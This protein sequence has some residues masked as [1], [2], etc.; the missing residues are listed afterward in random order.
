M[1]GGPVRYAEDTLGVHRTDAAVTERLGELAA[2]N[3]VASG[4]H[5]QKRQIAERLLLAEADI[6]AD[7]RAANP[8]MSQ[9]A[10][11]RHIKTALALST[12]CQALRGEQIEVQ[13]Q[14]D[15]AENGVREIEFHVRHG[16][17]R[18][19]ELGGLLRFY[20][21][22]RKHNTSTPPQGATP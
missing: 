2:A 12:R 20:A 1:T 13:H 9:A 17:A 18:L 7:E 14:I 6:V 11:D 4:L 16:I 3:A 15:L 21:A 19:E 5:H 22:A 10:F 8:E